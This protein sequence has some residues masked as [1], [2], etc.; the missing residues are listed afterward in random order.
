MRIENERRARTRIEMR[1]G[2]LL[3]DASGRQQ[4]TV[5]D[6]SGAGVG[7][8][9][10]HAPRN[11]EQVRV[12]ISLDGKSWLD[13]RGVVRHVRSVVGAYE[14]GIDLSLS[15]PE[16][17]GHV[18][19]YVSR[20]SAMIATARQSKMYAD[21]LAG[22]ES[23]E[24]TFK[25]RTQPPAST[26]TGRHRMVRDSSGRLR[27]VSDSNIPKR[28]TSE[29]SKRPTGER[30]ASS[31]GARRILR[32]TGERSSVG[33]S[34]QY[35]ASERPTPRDPPV[36]TPLSRRGQQRPGTSKHEKKT[37]TSRETVAADPQLLRLFKAAVEEVTGGDPKKKKK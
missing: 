11:G 1:G 24:P 20:A 3:F 17:L 27:P 22:A 15:D 5:R 7:V 8:R 37:P 2:A 32:P 19:A 33:D 12:V 26:E 21:R 30:R 25:P 16:V 10:S 34:G 23:L 4:V 35:P 31:S 6:L 9:T 29:Q 14:C 13:L 28:D 36:Q 18:E